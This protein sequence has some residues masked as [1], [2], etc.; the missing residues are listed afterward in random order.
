MPRRIKGELEQ[1]LLEQARRRVR[2]EHGADHGA[3]VRFAEAIG[4]PG[5]WVSDYLDG[6]RYPNL[7]TYIAIAEY[8]EFSLPDLRGAAPLEDRLSAA[9]RRVAQWF[10]EIPKNKQPAVSQLVKSYRKAPVDADQKRTERRVADR[11]LLVRKSHG[12]KRGA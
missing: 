11:P 7:D 2:R 3:Q 8:C 1:R 5:S 6:H 12:K 4:K 9:A 10:E